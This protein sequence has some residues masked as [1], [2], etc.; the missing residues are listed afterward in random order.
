MVT[1]KLRTENNGFAFS[2]C[3]KALHIVGGDAA[4]DWEDVT[5]KICL[6]HC[7]DTLNEDKSRSRK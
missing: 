1:H 3:G 7:E 4:D 2:K 6:K 5:C